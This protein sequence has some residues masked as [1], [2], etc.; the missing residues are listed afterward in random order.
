MRI[1][2]SR[3]G[4][5]SAAGGCPSPILQGNFFSLPIPTTKRSTITYGDLCEPIPRIVTDLTRGRL[6]PES[7]CHL[8]PDIHD[9]LLTR[10]RLRGWRG[11]LGQVGAAQ[12]H[13]KNQGVNGGDLFLFWGLF[14]H[15]RLEQDGRW[16]FFGPRQHAVFGWLQVDEV[17]KAGTNGGHVLVGNPWL[18]DHPHVESGWNENN[19]IYLAAPSLAVG[20][21]RTQYPGCG[22]FKRLSMLTASDAT[23]PSH[24]SVPKWL[25]ASEGGAGLTYHKPERWTG[26]G[27]LRAASRGQEF[28]AHPMRTVEATD[29]LLDLFKRHA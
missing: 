11:S 5:D 20:G 18:K 2:L 21:K 25:D 16:T 26:G 27:K 22:W 8:D 1:I 19:S 15:I 12:S 6:T 24:W 9:R 23:S 29:W 10:P 3:K 13:L 7:L 28:I 14:Q 17:I 4:F